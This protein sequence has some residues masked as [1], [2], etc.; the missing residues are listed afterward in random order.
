MKRRKK[1]DGWRGKSARLEKRAVSP[2]TLLFRDKVEDTGIYT[3]RMLSVYKLS[4]AI[5]CSFLS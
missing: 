1:E 3:Q 5:V 4:A 2:S